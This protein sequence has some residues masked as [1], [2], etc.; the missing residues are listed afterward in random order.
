MAANP[1][2]FLGFRLLTATLH[3][4]G[5]TEE[6]MLYVSHLHEW[7]TATYQQHL[8]RGYILQFLRK[9]RPLRVI[10]TEKTGRRPVEDAIRHWEAAIALQPS[11]PQTYE[12]LASLAD[13]Y[14]RENQEER[15]AE[16]AR[17]IVAHQPDRVSARVILASALVRQGKYEEARAHV[18]KALEL[19]PENAAAEAMLPLV[20]KTSE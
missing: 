19:D 17:R 6:A 7:E 10:Y 1:D 16:A 5:R 13:L 18:R 20:G 4:L 8:S 3:E 2:F 11:A 9:I 12:V 15:A 14:L